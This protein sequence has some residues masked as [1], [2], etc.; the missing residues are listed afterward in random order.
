MSANNEEFGID[1]FMAGTTETDIEQW[2]RMLANTPAIIF[3]GSREAAVQDIA[4]AIKPASMS[5]TNAETAAMTAWVVTLQEIAFLR[6]SETDFLA[7]TDR[8]EA[9]EGTTYARWS[10]LCRRILSRMSE[11]PKDPPCEVVRAIEATVK[12]IKD[13]QQAALNKG[14]TQ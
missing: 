13:T 1:A 11:N 3:A 9:P 5:L 4:E 7:I 8:P 2:D 6:D 12:Q 10:H 14:T